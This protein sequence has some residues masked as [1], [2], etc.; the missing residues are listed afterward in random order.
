MRV[1]HRIYDLSDA[2][3]VLKHEVASALAQGNPKRYERVFKEIH[4]HSYLE[5][6]ISTVIAEGDPCNVSYACGVSW[7]SLQKLMDYGCSEDDAKFIF[8][9]VFDAVMSI[10]QADPFEI[11]S[12]EDFT[13]QLWV[14]GDGNSLHAKQ[15]WYGD[16]NGHEN[17]DTAGGRPVTRSDQFEREGELS[18]HRTTVASCGSRGLYLRE[19]YS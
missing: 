3:Y 10:F 16:F 15:I 6:F 9:E 12:T 17:D 8:E 4:P 19:D 7:S 5:H 13:V 18:W 2:A 14:S 11:N 1:F